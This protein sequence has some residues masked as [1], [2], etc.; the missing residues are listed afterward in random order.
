[1]NCSSFRSRS[2]LSGLLASAALGCASTSVPSSSGEGVS[3]GGEAHAHGC[4][5]Q[6]HPHHDHGASAGDGSHDDFSDVECFAQMFDAPD[7][8]GWQRPDE[9]VALLAL[10]PGM[11]IAD[12]GAGTGYFEARLAAAVGE[13]GHVLALDV[14]PQM[15][16]YMRARFARESLA[17]VEA[18]AVPAGDPALAAE[19][20][21][22]VLVVDT[23]HHLG[24]RSAYAARLAA[25]LR[26]G[27]M[28]VIVDFTAESPEGPP[29]SMRLSA[30]VVASELAVAGLAAEVVD[31]TLPH[32]WV[33]RARRTD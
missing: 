27:G 22:R 20:I 29:A 11:T 16:A 14:E 26:P 10:A 6:G 4:H 24:D 23:W 30:D 7:R 8:D 17:N 9:V 5:E 25:A 2:C 33:V 13:T 1:M 28:V 32:Q 18:R 3:A 15:V 21:D 31:E 19:S 12:L